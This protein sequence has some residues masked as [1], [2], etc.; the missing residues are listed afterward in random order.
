MANE[1]IRGFKGFDK[2]LRCQ[3]Y[4]YEVGKEYEHPGEVKCC[5]NESDLRAGRG[6]FHFCENPID[7]WNYYGPGD[8]RFCEV[9]GVGGVA[10]HG[11]DS[12]VV[13]SKIRIGAEIKLSC[14]IE[15][16][17][18]FVLDGVD[19]KNKKESNTGDQSAATNTGDLSA[20]TNT[21]Y[22]SAATNTGDLSAATNTGDLSAATNTGYRSAAT[23]TGYRSAATNTGNQ[24]AAT[25]T[26]DRSA[27]T[28]TGYRS[29]ATV[30]GKESIACGL[31]IQSRAS[32]SLGCWLVLVEWKEDKGHGWHIKSVKSVMVD[33]KKI[34]ADMFYELRKG[35]FVLSK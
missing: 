3:G 4:Q 1:P 29:A 5:P 28:N 16:A 9:E 26:G 17:V 18:K 30:G 20:A 13:T 15:A 25:H 19:W 35:K 32:G 7:V 33:G 27:A 31:G 6:G 11:E 24:S 22:R 8:S 23:N 14:F 12:K 10:K 2:D 21:G 34:K